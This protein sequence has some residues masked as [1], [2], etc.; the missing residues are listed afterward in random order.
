[1][2]E[3]PKRNFIEAIRPLP[4]DP[5]LPRSAQ[6][7]FSAIPSLSPTWCLAALRSSLATSLMWRSATTSRSRSCFL[8]CQSS[9]CSSHLLC[10]IR[11]PCRYRGGG[12]EDLAGERGRKRGRGVEREGGIGRAVAAVG[13]GHPETS[14]RNGC[15]RQDYLPFLTSCPHT[16]LHPQTYT[17]PHLQITHGIEIGGDLAV[18]SLPAQQRSESALAAAQP[19]HQVQRT[20]CRDATARGRQEYRL[21]PQLPAGVHQALAAAGDAL[22]GLRGRGRG[23]IVGGR[24]AVS[25]Q[26]GHIRPQVPAREGYRQYDRGGVVS[27]RGEA[28]KAKG[29]AARRAHG[30]GSGTG[31][32]AF[33]G[34]CVLFIGGGEQ[35]YGRNGRI[36]PWMQSHAGHVWPCAHCAWG[37]AQHRRSLRSQNGGI[38]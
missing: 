3:R 17:P 37:G 33:F 21:V 10:R 5:P 36:R 2:R 27:V 9:S 18:A 26:G 31:C 14:R 19:Q 1:M 13:E 6:A 28:C 15:V 35:R 25:V 20:A 32:T 24:R 23:S 4:G 30:E 34:L 38:G 16:L 7:C 11:R 8:L 12:P 29:L 22:P